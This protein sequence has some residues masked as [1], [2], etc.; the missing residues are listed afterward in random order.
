MEGSIKFGYVC[1]CIFLSDVTTD[2]FTVRAACSLLHCAAVVT[3]FWQHRHRTFAFLCHI[4]TMGFSWNMGN[5]HANYICV[6]VCRIMLALAHE[7][8][9]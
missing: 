2:L 1:V 7:W 8:L 9:L 5:I 3:K 6:C 4:C